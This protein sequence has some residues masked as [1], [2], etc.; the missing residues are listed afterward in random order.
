MKHTD[1]NK[2]KI[3]GRQPY[4]TPQL[5]S[6]GQLAKITH[7]TSAS[8][9]PDGGNQP[10]KNTKP[11]L[12][13]RVSKIYDLD[14]LLSE[15]SVHGIDLFI[16]DFRPFSTKF[17]QA[18]TTNGEARAAS[19]APLVEPASWSKR[20]GTIKAIPYKPGVAPGSVLCWKGGFHLPDWTTRDKYLVGA[21][22]DKL[23][24]LP[25]ELRTG[26]LF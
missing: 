20:L 21:G 6:F 5:I 10:N 15:H 18:D 17:C 23:A 14:T 1:S 19:R 8:S 2:D 13:I 9:V 3:A 7:G 12:S 24:T 26:S 11:T 25:A 16:Q 4:F 22:W